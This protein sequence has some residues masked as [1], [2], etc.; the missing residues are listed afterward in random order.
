MMVLCTYDPEI[1]VFGGS[2][3]VALPFF[4]S[5]LRRQL[6]RFPQP[7]VVERLVIERSERLDIAVL[8]A[9]AL[10]LPGRGQA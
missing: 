3:S 6:V 2:V 1:I 10:C 5:A 8:G 9:A 7:H 4:E